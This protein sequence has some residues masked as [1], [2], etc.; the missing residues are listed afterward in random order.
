MRRAALALSIALL[1]AALCVRAG[2]SPNLTPKDALARLFTADHIDSNWFAQSFLDQVS[3]AQVETIV[4]QLKS[5][6]GAQQAR[7][8]GLA[9]S[10]GH[11]NGSIATPWWK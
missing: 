7:Q 4:G 2:A 1:V 8:S 3:A 11:L 5:Q 9:S 6:L 10:I